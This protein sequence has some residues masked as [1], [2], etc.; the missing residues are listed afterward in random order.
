MKAL[1]FLLLLAIPSGLAVAQIVYYK[2]EDGNLHAADSPD[3]IPEKY[4]KKLKTINS[5]NTG[6]AGSTL[7]KEAFKYELSGGKNVLLVDVGGT[8]IYM[9]IE[10]DTEVSVIPPAM[11]NKL[12]LRIAGN[13]E[14]ATAS[15]GPNKDRNVMLT[16]VVPR[17][18][19]KQF[20]V[21]N[22][23]VYVSE[24]KNYGKAEGILGRD[25]FKNFRVME[26]PENKSITLERK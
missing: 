11:I 13:A 20:Q 9:A 6:P 12:G 23:Q 1:F 15:V 24:L 26:E 22:M 8:E 21:T 7:S 25:Y 14:V 17:M 19:V 4:R 10:P 5:N 2:D 18:G 16:T 3:L